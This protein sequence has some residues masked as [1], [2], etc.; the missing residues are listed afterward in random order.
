MSIFST[1]IKSDLLRT[2]ISS[3]LPLNKVLGFSL[4]SLE[5]LAG[6]TGLG[7]LTPLLGRSSFLSSVLSSPELSVPITVTGVSMPD[8]QDTVESQP[9][10]TAMSE[11]R[12]TGDMKES[13]MEEPS[14]EKESADFSGDCLGLIWD[15]SCFSF[16]S[17]GDLLID[18]M[19]ISERDLGLPR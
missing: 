9:R 5:L 4:F 3:W 2:F 1:N 18:D 12:V 7:L 11:L 19:L 6:V 10:L 16:E 17:R 14:A 15:I 13:S 8:A